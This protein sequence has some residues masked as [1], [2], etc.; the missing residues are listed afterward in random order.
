MRL[1]LSALAYA[2]LLSWALL[3]S[4]IIERR[5]LA[6]ERAAVAARLRIAQG[7]VTQLR[8]VL[9][10]AERLL[11]TKDLDQ[12]LHDPEHRADAPERD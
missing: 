12:R 11:A 5:R 10:D 7:I 4:L 3:P 2:G 9:L 8:V 6:R 1:L